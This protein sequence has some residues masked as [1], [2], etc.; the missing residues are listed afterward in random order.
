MICPFSFTLSVVQNEVHLKNY[1]PT[2]H[3]WQGTKNLETYKIHGIHQTS[4][5]VCQM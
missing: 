4:M 1:N 3:G 5:H 2:R